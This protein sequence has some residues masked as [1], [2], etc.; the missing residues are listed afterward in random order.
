MYWPSD[1]LGRFQPPRS[2]VP[3]EVFFPDVPPRLDAFVDCFLLRHVRV[4]QTEIRQVAVTTRVFFFHVRHG[5]IDVG[6]IPIG[7]VAR[8]RSFVSLLVTVRARRA[9]DGLLQRHQLHEKYQFHVDDQD[10]QGDVF[11]WE[12]TYG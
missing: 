4:L 1:R 10:G 2:R 11:V 6:R 12:V 7:P 9:H 3:R 5:D 8:W